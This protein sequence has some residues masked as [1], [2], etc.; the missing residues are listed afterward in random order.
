[1]AIV[2]VSLVLATLLGTKDWAPVSEPGFLDFHISRC[3]ILDCFV[4]QHI[5][6]YKLVRY[7]GMNNKG[8][9][10]GPWTIWKVLRAISSTLYVSLPEIMKMKRFDCLVR[11]N[12]GDPGSRKL[13]KVFPLISV[14]SKPPQLTYGVKKSSF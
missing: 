3:L 14:L 10:D 5:S 2:V 1:M 8:V 12:I 9:L 11:Q 13:R 6:K 7:R 4:L